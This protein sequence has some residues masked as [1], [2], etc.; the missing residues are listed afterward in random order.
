MLMLLGVMLYA[1]EV[2][3]AFDQYRAVKAMTKDIDDTLLK[4]DAS[5][6]PAPFSHKDRLSDP[7]GAVAEYVLIAQSK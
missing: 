3:T 4:L 5:P 7:D 6:S 2:S 1:R